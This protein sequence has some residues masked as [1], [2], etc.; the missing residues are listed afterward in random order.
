MGRR[1]SQH[2]CYAIPGWCAPTLIAAGGCTCRSPL[3]RAGVARRDRRRR[4]TK[5]VGDAFDR[6]QWEALLVVATGSGKTAP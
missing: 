4:A 2:W 1:L 6:Q 5:K 3:R